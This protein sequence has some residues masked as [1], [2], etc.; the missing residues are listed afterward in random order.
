MQLNPTTPPSITTSLK[1]V[2]DLTFRLF[3]ISPSSLLSTKPNALLSKKLNPFIPHLKSSQT[4]TFLPPLHPS[5]NTPVPASVGKSSLNPLAVILY[6]LP[7]AR[8]K[9]S[10]TCAS[11]SIP[12]PFSLSGTAEKRIVKIILQKRKTK[13]QVQKSVWL[14]SSSSNSLSKL[15]FN[16]SSIFSS[17]SALTILNTTSIHFLLCYSSI[18]FKI[19]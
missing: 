17:F 13:A 9:H 4:F 1:N 12:H 3:S 2:K 8:S 7:F 10:L 19:P 15:S 16:S 14:P 5:M 18:I 6:L 11:Q